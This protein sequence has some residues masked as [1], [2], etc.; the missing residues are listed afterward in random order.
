MPDWN[1]MAVFYF[2][3]AIVIW[4]GF[5]S[6][7]GGLSF[8]AYV[9]SETARPLPD[10]TP[11]VS[12]IAPCR[13]PED[14]LGENIKALFQQDYPAYEIILVTDRAD[15]ASLTTFARIREAETE[16]VSARI[17]IAGKAIDRG[18]KVH[19]LTMAVAEVDPR[20]EVFVFVDTDARP[21]A[22]WLRA[23]V[24]PLA[25]ERVGA[26][27]GY[28]WFISKTGGLASQFRSVW[29][30]SIAS[31]LGE[32]ADKNFCWGGSTAIRKST[33]EKLKI[34]ERWQGTVSDDFTLTRVLQEAKLPIH[35]VPACLV[36]SVGDCS[37]K[38]LLEFTNRQ[39][40]ITR[41]YSAHLWKPVLIGSL[42]F[43][44]VFFGGF[45]LVVAR[46]MMRL[47]FAVPLVA[48]A[49]IYL[50][51]AAKSYVRLK[52][53]AIPLASYRKQLWRSLPAHLL[54]WPFASALYLCN[55]VTAA[56]S[57]RI[58]WRGITYELKSATEAVI[59][60]RE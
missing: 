34:I 58:K 56:F 2:F 27:S 20:S 24:S 42:L 40:K 9:R 23:L 14:G 12:V 33:F 55:A 47:P 45:A 30:A 59:I 46:A 6:L 8:A 13:G 37:A 10:F 39:L 7:R 41:V 3:A 51:G 16:Q 1:A 49:L 15:D 36:A 38:E 19:N 25:D 22:N 60:S 18:Q 29:N 35:F 26:A 43:C 5:L 48:L 4:L 31:A 44:L 11:F 53:V 57:R 54:L 52:A 28:R 21:Q 17:V 50:L 32:R